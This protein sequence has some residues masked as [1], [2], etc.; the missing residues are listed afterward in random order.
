[1]SL[2][3]E[4]FSD[5]FARQDSRLARI[6]PRAKLL[7]A[8]L[9]IVCV[10]L[11][12]RALFPLAVFVACVGL[13]LAHGVPARLVALRL[14]APLGIVAVLVTLQSLLTGAT[15]LWSAELA[16]WKITATRDGLANGLCIGARVLGAVSVVLLLSSVTPAHRI[17]HAL[18]WCRVPQDWVEVA[19]LMYRYTF[20]FLDLVADLTAAQ[21]VRLGY[22]KCR[23]GLSSLGI[24]AGTV[25]IR[26]VD[27]AVHTHEAMLMRG[28]RGQIPFGPMA[29]W[30]ARD[31]W[32]TSLAGAG[33]VG[34]FWLIEKG[35]AR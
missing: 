27:Q 30:R 9:T 6:D 10:V 32:L 5:I 15:P 34:G 2:A 13:T 21:R 1:M 14:T 29:A 22:S 24:V 18:R 26:S 17:F 33:V 3:T 11:S 16:G 31:W 19:V 35:L 8:L 28:Y 4:L 12:T 25:I 23:C 7:V 20:T